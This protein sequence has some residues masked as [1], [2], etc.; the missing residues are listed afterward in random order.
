MVKLP[1]PV[2]SAEA[3]A[4][5]RAL[6]D[7]ILHGADFAA[8]AR[9]ESADS[10]S[11]AQGGELPMFGHG[12]MVPAFETAAFHLPIGQVSEPVVSPFG[13]HL[14]KVERRTADSVQA[15]HILLPIARSGARLDT[16]EARAD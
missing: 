15:R 16:L 6:R 3:M 2:D 8:I 12:R 7:S 14:I 11:R 5:A 1:T 9:N 4:H 10:G 13:V